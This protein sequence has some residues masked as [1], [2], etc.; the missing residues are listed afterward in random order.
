MKKI[1]ILTM[2]LVLLASSLAVVSAAGYVPSVS[3]EAF[4]GLVTIDEDAEGN[5]I[6]GY[7]VDAQ[8]EVLSNEYHGCILITPVIDAKNGV[9]YLSDAA[10]ELL[11]DTHE[12]LAAQD[13]RLSVLIPELND[14]AKSALGEGA[15]AD[16]LVIRE[17][18]DVTAVC[19]DLIK[20]LEVE[21][22]TITLTFKMVVPE[23]DFLT[24]MTL[25]DGKWEQVEEVKNNDDGT[26]SVKFSQ[27]CPVLFLT[28][29]PLDAAAPA[30]INLYWVI[31]LCAI[32]LILAVTVC[33][34]LRRKVK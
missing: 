4:P 23:E 9:S 6:V 5:G 14:I 21:G 10:E 8:G 22:N 20:L 27:F 32:I 25:N 2:V 31:A 33:F 15:T 26:V 29:L 18:F 3:Y 11:V 13:A 1:M 34:L 17:L 16:D 30:Q 7:V 24:V 12:T 28:G 19:E